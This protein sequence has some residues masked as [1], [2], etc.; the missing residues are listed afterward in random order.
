MF[1][2][3]RASYEK[4]WGKNYEKPGCGT[5]ILAFFIR[6][7]PKIGPLRMLSLRMPTPETE[8]MFEASFNSAFQEFQRSLRNL[9]E[10]KIDLPNRNLDTGGAVA[11]GTYFMLEGAYSRL[12]NQLYSS[13]FEHVTPPL[14][15]DIIEHFAGWSPGARIRRDKLDKT[16]VDWSQVT[17]QLQSLTD[18]PR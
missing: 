12:L 10:K 5:R 13:K 15:A 16:G 8:Q 7:I 17:Q 11:R 4:E 9:K 6:L 2:L 1:N 14:R 18:L 3:S